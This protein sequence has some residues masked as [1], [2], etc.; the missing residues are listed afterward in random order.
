[1]VLHANNV[2]SVDRLIDELWGAEPP[3]SALN[4]LQG[5]VSHLRKVL[6]PHRGRGEHELL[7]SR[8]PGY[9]LQIRPEQLDA[10]RFDRLVTEGRR[11]LE[12]GDVDPAAAR[13]RAA[14]GLRR[15]PAPGDLGYQ[16]FARPEA[17]RLEELRLL[18]VEDRIDAEL[19]AGRHD[20][21]VPEL[22]ELVGKNP[23]RERLCAQLMA[24]MYRS[25]RQADAL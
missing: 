11:L 3:E 24:A 5:Y 6:E 4:M 21:L 2:V 14:L 10:E 9:V 23:L 22:R 19:A 16:R 17:E 25:G 7:V 1:L 12:E 20:V 18:A 13:L 15:G 8:P